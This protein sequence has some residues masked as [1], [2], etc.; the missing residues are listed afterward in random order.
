M[1]TALLARFE[2]VEFS[3]HRY[4]F[5]LAVIILVAI[6]FR[7]L[8]VMELPTA[9]VS[10]FWSYSQ[11][12]ISL[13]D[14]GVYEAIPGRPDASY[15]PGYPLLLSLFFHL[16]VD[17]LITA[18]LINVALGIL[19][20][21]LVVVITKTLFG[22]QASL[23][24]SVIYAVTPRLVLS[25]VLLASENLFIPLI[26]LWVFLTIWQRTGISFGISILSGIILGLATLTRSVSW[27]LVIPWIV[28]LLIRRVP[29]QKII[30]NVFVFL[31]AQAVVLL[32]GSLHNTRVLGSST[33]L[34]TTSGINLYIGNNPNSSG[35]WY[36]WL[37]DMQQIDPYFSNR[38][39]IDQD[40][41]ARITAIDWILK[42]PL[43]TGLMYIKKWGMIFANE[44][45]V[46]E[47]SIYGQ[48]LSPPWP[49]IDVL[50][51][52]SVFLPYRG[53]LEFLVNG[54][55]WLILML[56][57]IGV[58]LS[59]VKYRKGSAYFSNWLLLVLSILYFPAVS[60]IFIASSRFHWPSMDLLIPFAAV[61]L[62]V[63]ASSRIISQ[64]LLFMHI[65]EEWVEG[66]LIHRS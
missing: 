26:L 50:E 20:L 54:S 2:T 43:Q 60:A 56:G 29:A 18:K 3:T 51:N 55:Y 44:N 30:L 37:D 42:N 46:L 4:R 58:I 6:A 23:F 49:A 31:L 27:L 66:P 47:T 45:F 15:P 40:K 35:Q 53:L 38:S 7:L 63:I 59:W 41:I 14:R 28:W 57:V 10:D 5:V 32:P 11:R 33:F 52:N 64:I 65:K 21:I 62:A 24:A 61:T 1:G 12:A 9:P 13:A 17:R 22:R 16:P 34:T 48:Q 36:P 8:V 25:C 39:I 19:G